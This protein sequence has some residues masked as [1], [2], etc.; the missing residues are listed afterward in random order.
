V[1]EASPSP[2]QVVLDRFLTELAANE[3]LGERLFGKDDEQGKPVA[4]GVFSRQHAALLVMVHRGGLPPSMLDDLLPGGRLEIT[5]EQRAAALPLFTPTMA[6]EMAAL[7]QLRQAARAAQ[8]PN[9]V[10]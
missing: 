1:G 10:K 5:A 7:F 9:G 3:P 8:P 2:E 4:Q 6:A